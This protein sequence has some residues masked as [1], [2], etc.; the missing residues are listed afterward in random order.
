M[1]YPSMPCRRATPETA[2]RFY[3]LGH[4]MPLAYEACPKLKTFRTSVDLDGIPFG[5]WEFG[6]RFVDTRVIDSRVCQKKFPQVKVHLT[7]R[8]LEDH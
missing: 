5:S 2:L 8:N 3:P 4:P 6:C 7:V 1:P